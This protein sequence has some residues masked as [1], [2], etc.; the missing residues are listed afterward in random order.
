VHCLGAVCILM[1]ILPPL[2]SISCTHVIPCAPA[3]WFNWSN[4]SW[5]LWLGNGKER[6]SCKF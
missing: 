1:L 5:G 6:Q 4:R 3:P 2:R